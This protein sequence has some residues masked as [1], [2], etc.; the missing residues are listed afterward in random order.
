MQIGKH[1]CHAAAVLLLIGSC[2]PV[3][4]QCHGIERNRSG[5][6]LGANVY[7]TFIITTPGRYC[8]T[9]DITIGRKFVI[10]EG[11]EQSNNTALAAVRASDVEIDLRG[12]SLVADALGTRVLDV[13]NEEGKVSV[14][15]LTVH[16]GTLR[17]R[18][19]TGVL[20]SHLLGPYF[21]SIRSDFTLTFSDNRAKRRN[22]VAL[23]QDRVTE[24]L[25]KIRNNF[26]ATGY[27]LLNLTVDVGALGIHTRRRVWQ[28]GIAIQG[29][30]N[31]IR[32][33]NITTNRAHAGIY[34]F[35]PNQ[36]IENNTIIFKGS[37]SAP[38][39]A[40]IKLHAADNSIIRNNTI[41]V[42]G[43][44]GE[45]Q[46]AISLIDSRNVV[47][48][49]NR[50]IGVDRLYKVWD[51][52]PEQSSSVVERGNTFPNLWDRLLGR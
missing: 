37:P 18:S 11:G 21:G 50:I 15:R 12:H 8:L 28:S 4:A 33:S 13:E 34:L 49:N 47:I 5:D 51:E 1:R 3:A 46:A 6:Y 52:R 24:P 9:Q 20:A 26:P 25:L 16:N 7:D 31:Q 30:G 40:P 23:L 39:G 36:V 43:W 10:S 44:L 27:K 17:S 22:D 48:E 41:V 45:P 14:A 19:D 29:A 32:G 42:E 38:S 35:G 2:G